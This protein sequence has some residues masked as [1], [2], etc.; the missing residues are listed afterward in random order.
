M[1]RTQTKQSSVHSN[2]VS[3]TETFVEEKNKYKESITKTKKLTI[4]QLQSLLNESFDTIEEQDEEIIQ[5]IGERDA[6]KQGLDESLEDIKTLN[7]YLE[8]YEPKQIEESTITRINDLRNRKDE[9]LNKQR[10]EKSEL[11]KQKTLEIINKK[12]EFSNR[13]RR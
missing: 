3:K 4:E 2:P 11:I 8:K 5:L 1:S 13:F 12:R 6:Y 10:K 9:R 7:Q